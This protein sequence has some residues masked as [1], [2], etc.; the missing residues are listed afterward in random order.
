MHTEGW[1]RRPHYA[2]IYSP[3][4]LHIIGVRGTFWGHTG[5]KWKLDRL[6]RK[7]LV[8][9]GSWPRTWQWWW[10]V[11]SGV[12]QT[13]TAYFGFGEGRTLGPSD[14]HR[15]PSF[16]GQDCCALPCH[17]SCTRVRYTDLQMCFWVH[18]SLW[19]RYKFVSFVFRRCLRSIEDSIRWSLCLSAILY[20]RLSSLSDFHEIR[21]MSYL[22]KFV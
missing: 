22:R 4:T 6:W 12:E 14:P 3:F 19:L 8:H 11:F 13:E 5:S 15:V 10:E 1:T 17:L 7:V 20:Q 2:F 9:M 18:V 16:A 21:Y